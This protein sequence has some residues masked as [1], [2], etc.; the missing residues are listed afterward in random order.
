LDKSQIFFFNT[1]PVIQ[2]HISRLLGV[3]RSSLSSNYPGL[4]LSESVE[5]NIFWDSLI[6]SISN[7]LS[8]YT[9]RT[10]NIPSRLILLKEMFQAIPTYIFL[11]LVVPQ[12]IIKSIIKIQQNFL[13]HGHEQGKKWALVS[14]EKICRPTPLGR[15]AL[16]DPGKLNNKMGVKICWRWIKYPKE[17]QARLW[18]QKYTPQIPQEHLIR[19][20]DQ[21]HG[22][23]ISNAAWRNCPLIQTHAFWEV[24]NGHHA[25]F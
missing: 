15:L 12:T 7:R 10:L 6:L 21:I 13:S 16:R 24:Q 23:N 22:S 1:P 25:Q 17:L 14:W 2:Q 19:L 3:P 18:R 5:W 9:F 20:D 4:P 8:S 11:G